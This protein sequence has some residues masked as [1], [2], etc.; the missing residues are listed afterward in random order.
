MFF[1]DCKNELEKDIMVDKE[2]LASGS[3]I[4]QMWSKC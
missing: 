3:R 2:E 4:N 1:S